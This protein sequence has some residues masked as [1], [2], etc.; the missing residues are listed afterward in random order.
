M[1]KPKRTKKA[2]KELETAKEID[3]RFP[4][5]SLTAEN[6]F[7]FYMMDFSKKESEKW[8]AKNYVEYRDEPF[9]FIKLNFIS[10]IVSI[11]GKR[12]HLDEDYLIVDSVAYRINDPHTWSIV[13][14]INPNAKKK[15]Y[16]TREQLS[17]YKTGK[18]LSV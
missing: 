15:K 6:G 8:E 7:P 12:A 10:P 4:E 3:A 9:D 16:I 11:R 13:S 18:T 2:E 1:E 17:E 14:E 5:T